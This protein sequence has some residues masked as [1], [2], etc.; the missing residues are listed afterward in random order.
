MEPLLSGYLAF[1]KINDTPIDPAKCKKII[2]CF[3]PYHIVS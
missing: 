2:E 3:A 1:H